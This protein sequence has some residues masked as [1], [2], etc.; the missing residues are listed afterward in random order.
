VQGGLDRQTGV[1]QDFIAFAG[2]DLCAS[3]VSVSNP[4]D[5][6][7]QSIGPISSKYL[8]LTLPTPS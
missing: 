6:G 3:V 8:R 2:Y 7:F 1:L 5:P 4:S